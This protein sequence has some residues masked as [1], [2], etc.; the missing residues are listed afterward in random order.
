MKI[1]ISSSCIH[2]RTD[3]LFNEALRARM[4]EAMFLGLIDRPIIHPDNNMVIDV[5]VP[6]RIK[7][8]DIDAILDNGGEIE[9]D[10]NWHLYARVIDT[11]VVPDLLSSEDETFFE[12][13]PKQEPHIVRR[14]VDGWSYFGLNPNGQNLKASACRQLKDAGMT[15]LLPSEYRAATHIEPQDTE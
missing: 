6:D 11:E 3:G 15:L 2:D 10:S 5:L 1:T 8:A 7:M 9:F 4:E 13:F 14:K 12:W